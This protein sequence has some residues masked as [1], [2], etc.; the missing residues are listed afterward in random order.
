[1]QLT[2]LPDDWSLN[3]LGDTDR[4]AG[5][6]ILVEYYLVDEAGNFLVD[7]AGNFLV[8]MATESVYPQM[9]H[10]L[11]DDFALNAE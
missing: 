6:T 1:M 10:A 2:A 11:P 4:S 7:T 8:G 9:L 5:T 3:A